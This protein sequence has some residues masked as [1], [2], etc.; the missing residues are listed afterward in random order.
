MFF[1]GYIDESYN[2]HVF[3]LSALLSTSKIWS[4]FS[5]EWKLMLDSWNRKLK[6]QGRPSISRYH[7]ADCSNLKREFSGWQEG[8]QRELFVDILKIF[9]RRQVDTVALSLNLDDLDTYFPEA[10]KEARPDFPKFIYGVMTKFLI[11]RIA[12]RDYVKKN[13]NNRIALIHDGCA[14]NGAMQDA[15]IQLKNDQSFPYRECFTTFA[16]SDWK[17]CILLQPADL[18]AYENF[19]DAMRKISP[20]NR[21]PSMKRLIDLDAFSGRAQSMS[22]N[23]ILKLKEGMITAAL[24]LPT[25]HLSSRPTAIRIIK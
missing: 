20:R 13:T 1:Q 23:A 17:N 4:E 22:K 24:S 11:E 3:T 9:K 16:P 18:V 12:D 5:R 14:Y 8:E 2:K 21:R 19:K 7:A 10:K 25:P 6:K 15:F